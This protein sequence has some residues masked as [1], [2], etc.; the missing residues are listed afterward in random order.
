MAMEKKH[1]E[2]VS[3]GAYGALRTDLGNEFFR[4]HMWADGPASV[5]F[6]FRG[7]DDKEASGRDELEEALAAEYEAT[8]RPVE[9]R[10]MELAKHG[11][12]CPWFHK[13]PNYDPMKALI[14]ME[15]DKVALDGDYV[16]PKE[17]WDG[18]RRAMCEAEDR[19]FRDTTLQDDQAAG[20]M[21][22]AVRENHRDERGDFA[23]EYEGTVHAIPRGDVEPMAQAVGRRQ[24]GPRVDAAYEAMVAT[25]DLSM[26]E[27]DAAR[28]PGR[29]PERHRL[30]GK[31]MEEK[32]AQLEADLAKSRELELE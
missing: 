1:Y 27:A 32:A 19:R 29:R 30:L 6:P 9:E 31:A 26:D 23:F 11:I 16:I 10:A 15:F 12:M 21:A 2:M 20:M 24:P 4:Y 3:D 8:V 22:R 7:E 28:Y 13:R 14:G 5:F 17:T 18:V 25:P